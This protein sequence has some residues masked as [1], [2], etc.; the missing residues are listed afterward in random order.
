VESMRI[1]PITLR[2][3]CA[4]VKAHHRH[5]LP[6]RGHKFSVAAEDDGQ[7]V[8][9]AIVGRPV[10]RVLD[11]GFTLEVTRVCTTGRKNACSMLYGAA[12]RIAKEMGYRKIQTYTLASERGTSLKASDWRCVVLVEGQFW[13]RRGRRRQDN[14]PTAAKQRWESVPPS[15]PWRRRPD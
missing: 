5:H 8:G 11:D 4:F 6:P 14:H 3:A 9:V 2:A 12:R 10:A 1:A 13:D 15:G 7:V